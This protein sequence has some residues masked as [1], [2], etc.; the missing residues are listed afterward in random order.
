M[1]LGIS[2]N[3][4]VNCSVASLRNDVVIPIMQTAG[5]TVSRV[6]EPLKN[7][8]VNFHL[9]SLT[10]RDCTHFKVFALIFLNQMLLSDLFG[11]DW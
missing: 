2:G 3:R 9:H 7:R 1:D 10:K 4:G 8:S 6:Y 5:I 11:N